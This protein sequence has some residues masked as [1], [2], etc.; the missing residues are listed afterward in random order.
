MIRK[1]PTC[2][3]INLIHS[4][5]SPPTIPFSQNILHPFTIPLNPLIHNALKGEG[6][7]SPFTET[8]SPDL[9]SNKTRKG[10]FTTPSPYPSNGI[11]SQKSSFSD[12]KE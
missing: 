5:A 11:L 12:Q 8:P 3:K 1:L 4:K 6:Y 7:P 10:S 9:Q 2:Y